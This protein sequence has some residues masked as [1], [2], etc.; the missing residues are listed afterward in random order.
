MQTG[1]LGQ[2]QTV[3]QI[4]EQLVQRKLARLDEQVA[5]RNPAR[6]GGVSGRLAARFFRGFAVV[7]QRF[8][9][10]A[11]DDVLG[12]GRRALAVK[13][14]ARHAPRHQRIIRQRDGRAGDGFALAPREQG[15]TLLRV[16]GG[17]NA[18]E[19]RQQIRHRRILDDDRIYAALH[20]LGFQLQKRILVAFRRDFIRFQR[21]QTIAPAQPAAD[22]RMIAVAGD[23]ACHRAD[24]VAAVRKV[25]PQRVFQGKGFL[26][27][28][29]RADIRRQTRIV[30]LQIPVHFARQSDFLLGSRAADRVGIVAHLRILL[31][32]RQ[33]G[34]LLIRFNQRRAVQYALNEH[35]DALLGEGLRV[36][37]A[38]APADLTAKGQADALTDLIG[39]QLAAADA[40]VKGIALRAGGF[41]R[42]NAR[43]LCRRKQ[44]GDELRKIQF[45]VSLTFRRL[46]DCLRG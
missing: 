23:G 32:R 28:D 7:Q 38:D 44:A 37:C 19:G 17:E 18:A 10:A 40:G 6:T 46:S 8:Q 20:A 3:A 45:H 15:Q 31:V 34:I 1:N 39:F 24:H 26:R 13:R 4:A 43:R 25:K 2:I 35:R 22:R 36:G 21:I 14:T 42:R 5:R 16:V 9:H 41:R 11:V 27:R 30:A 12:I 29:D 33:D